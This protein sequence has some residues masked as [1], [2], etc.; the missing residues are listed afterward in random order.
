M[1][2][3]VAHALEVGAEQVEVTAEAER[4]WSMRHA[5]GLQPGVPPAT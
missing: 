4:A 5:G 1:E 2:T 3:V